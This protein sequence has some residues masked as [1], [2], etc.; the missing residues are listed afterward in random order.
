[1]KQTANASSYGYD[2]R[3]VKHRYFFAEKFYEMD[4]KKV[5][6]GG[7]MGTRI[8]DLAEILGVAE[9]PDISQIAYALN[10]KTWG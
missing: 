7:C 3:T 1:M 10:Q 2:L 9:M 6:P 8:F 4:Y 5:T